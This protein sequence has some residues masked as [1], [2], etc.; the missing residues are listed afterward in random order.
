MMFLISILLMLM[1]SDAYAFSEPLVR[2]VAQLQRELISIG[3][4]LAALSLVT[5]VIL[6][7]MGKPQ[8]KWFMYVF[9]GAIILSGFTHVTNWMLEEMI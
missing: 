3:R 6:F 4:A 1:V 7:M 5:I 2:K 9:G 8:W